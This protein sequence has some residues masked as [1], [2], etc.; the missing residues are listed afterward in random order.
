MD[1]ERFDGLARTVAERE[2]ERARDRALFDS[3]ARLVAAKRSRRLALAGLVGGAGALLGQVAQPTAAQ[4]RGKEDKNKRQCRRDRDGNAPGAGG[5][6]CAQKNLFG[7]CVAGSVFEDE[8]CCNNMVCTP[9]V[10]VF[11]WGCQYLCETDADCKRK[12]PNKALACR[13]DALV[14]PLNALLGGKC[15]VPR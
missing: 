11:V 6:S 5:G 9:T 10:G 8:P 3:L 13:T 7:L 1:A 14:C 15:C 4:C 12:F 2:E